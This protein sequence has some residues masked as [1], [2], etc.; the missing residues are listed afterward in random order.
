[1][2]QHIYIAIT[3]SIIYILLKLVLEKTN[4]NKKNENDKT[5]FRDSFYIGVIVFI[6]LYGYEYYFTNNGEKTKVFTN[7][8]DF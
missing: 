3:V 5:I 7:E 2:T 4:K 8:P 1:M 6:V